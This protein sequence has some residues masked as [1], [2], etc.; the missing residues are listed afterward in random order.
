MLYSSYVQRS[1]CDC[2]TEFCLPLF[3]FCLTLVFLFF[4]SVESKLSDR[5]Q[6]NL[7]NNLNKIS[8]PK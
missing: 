3:A 5:S 2:A 4:K 6:L 7:E 8:D 1:I